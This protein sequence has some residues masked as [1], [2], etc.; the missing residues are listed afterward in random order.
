[1]LTW[2]EFEEALL[3]IGLSLSNLLVIY[4]EDDV[5]LPVLYG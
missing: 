3:D 1:M 4:V 5:H 2:N